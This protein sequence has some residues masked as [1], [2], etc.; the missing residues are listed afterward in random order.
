M[1]DFCYNYTA[2][3]EYN[4]PFTNG[5]RN[6]CEYEFFFLLS[7][8]FPPYSTC[9]SVCVWSELVNYCFIVNIVIINIRRIYIVQFT[10]TV[11]YIHTD[12]RDNRKDR[13]MKLLRVLQ[14]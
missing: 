7:R 9:V 10:H 2:Y 13:L 12:A 4:C 11:R 6:A 8:V 14:N 1:I 3:L 5:R